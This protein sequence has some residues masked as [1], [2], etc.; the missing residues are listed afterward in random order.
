MD[1]NF[2]Q[3]PDGQYTSVIYSL[4]RDQKYFEV[5]IARLDRCR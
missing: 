3:V 2:R 5:T 1:Q 4:I